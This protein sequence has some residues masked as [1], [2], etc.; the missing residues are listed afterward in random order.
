V[1]EHGPVKDVKP[2]ASSGGSP[3]HPGVD[4]VVVHYRSGGMLLDLVGDVARQVQIGTALHVVECGDDG[5]V[6]AAREEVAFETQDPG[7]NLGY[8]GG[9]N[10]ALRQLVDSDRPICLVNP[11]V[12]MVDQRTLQQMVEALAQDPGLAAVAPSIRTGNGRIE[13]TGSTIDLA[14]AKIHHTGT[15]VPDW[16]PETPALVE[17]EWIDGACWMLRAAA[18]R[19]VGL[20]DERFFLFSEE[21]DWCRRATQ[22]GWR[23][24]VLRDV[25]VAHER[26][27][28]F[29]TSTK[30]AYYAWRNRYLM[31]RKYEGLGSWVFFWT[32]ALLAF[33]RRRQHRRSGESGSALRGARD[34]LLGRTGPMPGDT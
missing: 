5:S 31:C 17:M 20:L 8:S 27:S 10:L 29:G 15:Y 25:E 7:A 23:V 13:Y 18:V 24:A 1:S 14:R 11:D 22:Q 34:A 32:R 4:V 33:A 3:T 12:R 16:P 19:D 9:N 30:G 28:S 26:S 2:A 21:A 6:A